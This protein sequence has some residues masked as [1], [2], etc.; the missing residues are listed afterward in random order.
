[1]AGRCV[2]TVVCYTPAR[3]VTA[4]RSTKAY[5]EHPLGPDA[6]Q[7]HESAFPSTR[8]LND[9]IKMFGKVGPEP[10]LPLCQQQRDLRKK[11]L[12]C[13][14]FEVMLDGPCGYPVAGEA[15]VPADSSR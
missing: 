12:S 15:E 6:A 13:V 9:S 3:L 7:P 14:R 10:S 5:G 2:I 8:R 11:T 4:S 1:M